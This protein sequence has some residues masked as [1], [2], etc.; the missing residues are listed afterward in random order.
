MGK[1]ETLGPGENIASIYYFFSHY[2]LPYATLSNN[3]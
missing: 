3:I 2:I 1:K